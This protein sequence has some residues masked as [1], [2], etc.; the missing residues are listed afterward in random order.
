L[1]AALLALAAIVHLDMRA[2]ATITQ[3][4]EKLRRRLAPHPS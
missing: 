1:E 2:R 4:L 3:Q